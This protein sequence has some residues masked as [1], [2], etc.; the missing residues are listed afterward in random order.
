MAKTAKGTYRK[1]AASSRLTERGM[2]AARVQYRPA[3]RTSTSQ[4]QP[5]S[6]SKQQAK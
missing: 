6:T 1:S 3:P 5:P 2:Q 4:I